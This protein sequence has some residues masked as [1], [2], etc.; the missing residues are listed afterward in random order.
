MYIIYVDDERPALDNFR[1]SVAS[2]LNI[3]GLE[4]FQSGA[5]ALEWARLH[6]VDVAFLDMEMPGIHGLKLAKLLKEV[7]PELQVVFVTAYSQYALEAWKADA[8]GYLLKPYSTADIEKA[9]IKCSR[10]RPDRKV[11]ITTIPTL[12]V[13]VGGEPLHIP[14]KKTRE[15]FAL[16]VDHGDRGITTGEGIAYLWPDRPGDAATQSLFRMTY[17][18][19]VEALEKVGA[20]EIIESREKRRYIRTDLVDCDLYRI[21]QGDR[22][23]A[24]KYDGQYMREYSWAED[25]NGQIGRILKK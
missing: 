6:V 1:L 16:L 22:T 18:R 25:R 5:E 17:K 7:N 20:G 9:L 8:S 24:R 19:L 15:L 4:L 14:G 12:E 10:G 2:I 23:A 21:L 3:R 11:R 13:R